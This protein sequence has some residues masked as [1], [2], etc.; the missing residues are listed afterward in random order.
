MSKITRCNKILKA[1]KE[2]ITR[3]VWIE[4]F[5]GG[6]AGTMIGI[7]HMESLLFCFVLILKL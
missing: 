4:F 5:F 3:K 6:Q 2:V 7:E 1:F